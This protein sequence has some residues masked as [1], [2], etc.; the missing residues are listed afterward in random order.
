MRVSI[1]IVTWNAIRY[2][3]DCLKAVFGQTERDFKVVIIDNNSNDGTVEFVR[4]NYPDV[5]LLQNFKNLGFPRAANQAI[6]FWDSEFIL[7]LNP[8][9]ILTP[10]YLEKLLAAAERYSRAGAFGGK[11]LKVGGENNLGADLLD[12]CGMAATKSRRFYERGEGE[13][14]RNKYNQEEEVFGICAGF[15]LFRRQALEETK[16]KVPPRLVAN[17][18][19]VRDDYEYLDENFFAYKEDVDIAWR[20]QWAGWK[21]IYVPSAEARHYRGA[22]GHAKFGNLTVIKDRWRKSKLIN[23]W[24]YKNHWLT[25][26]KNESGI[27]FILAFPWIFSYELK[28]FIYILFLEPGTLR[29]FFKEFFGQFWLT[30][31]KRKQIKKMKKVSN[32]EIREWF[33]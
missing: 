10:T 12:S 9:V 22:K 14:D 8:D 3:D 27:N 23:R 7:L 15:I 20:L 33:K 17:G 2:I 29:F 24:S 19:G 18:E 1:N 11:I 25:L 5:A 30:L 31:K 16:I 21:A 32:K 26:I 4:A 6:Q 28:K 13:E